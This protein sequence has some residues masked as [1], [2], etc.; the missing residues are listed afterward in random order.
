MGLHLAS[1]VGDLF[2]MYKIMNAEKYC[3][4]L[5][6]SVILYEKHCLRSVDKNEK[7]EIASFLHEKCK[8]MS[9]GSR[10][11]HSSIFHATCL[12]H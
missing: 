8:E 12:P 11:L 1:G 3:H 10:L 5:V 2:K 6:H 4:I 9:C 7:G